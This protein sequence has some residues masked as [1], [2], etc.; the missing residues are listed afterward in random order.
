MIDIYTFVEVVWILW[1]AYG[2]NGLC[3]LARGKR[4]IDGGRM[5][6]SKQIFGPGKTWEGLL[7][8]V[9]IGALVGT[10][11]MLAYPFLPWE[12]S[13]VALS[14]VPMSPLIGALIG[15]GALLGDIGGSFIK[16]RL[17]IARG[18]PAPIL[19]QLDFIAG[20]LIILALVYPL[21][22]E[23]VVILVVMTPVFHLLANRIAY[24]LKLKN[25]P[26]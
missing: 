9:F 12:L 18:K 14:L 6:R 26:Y 8:G 20:M 19:D 21:K 16:R 2:A 10:I 23:W 17:N 1:P 13:P 11:Q 7:F 24:M 25:V 4:A 5:W 22:W 15:L 3:M